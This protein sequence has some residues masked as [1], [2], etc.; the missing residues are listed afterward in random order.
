MFHSKDILS[1][2]ANRILR[3]WIF[4]IEKHV[5]CADSILKYIENSTK[6][7]LDN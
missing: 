6:L 7:E 1:A 2:Y 5:L 4:Y 3:I